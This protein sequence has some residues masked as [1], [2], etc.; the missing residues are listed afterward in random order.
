MRKAA[1]LFVTGAVLAAGVLLRPSP[2]PAVLPA[3]RPPLAT[4]LPAAPRVPVQSQFRVSSESGV[5]PGSERGQNGVRTGSEFEYGA[6]QVGGTSELLEMRTLAI[7][8]DL[9][10]LAPPPATARSRGT[11]SRAFGMAGRQTSGAFRTAGRAIRL[12]F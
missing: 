11:V 1:A 6:T 8:A 7:P 12:A 9:P 4:A 5:R 10:G 2:V 3:L